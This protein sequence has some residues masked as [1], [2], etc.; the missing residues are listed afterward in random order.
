MT[1]L[2]RRST[3]DRSWWLCGRTGG[4]ISLTGSLLRIA[5]RRSSW[6]T[7]WQARLVERRIRGGTDTL[8]HVVCFDCLLLLLLLLLLQL[9]LLD[10]GLQS[11]ELFLLIP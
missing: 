1:S 5:G 11:P 10:L 8:A 4:S 2:D 7:T 9:D 3:W 6:W